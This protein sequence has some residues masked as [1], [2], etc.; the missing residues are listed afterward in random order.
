MMVDIGFLRG[1]LICG[2]LLR[3]DHNL[4]SDV[5]CLIIPSAETSEP[6][7]QKLNDLVWEI[8]GNWNVPLEFVVVNQKVAA[9]SM[10]TISPSF[11][12]HLRWAV[13]YGGVVGRNPLEM[14][15]VSG[16]DGRTDAVNYL[17]SKLRKLEK[18]S[19]SLS[20][21]QIRDGSSYI[22]ALERAFEAPLRVARV[23]LWWTDPETEKDSRQ[24]VLEEY[25]RVFAQHQDL[26]AD[27]GRITRE[28]EGYTQLL[29]GIVTG[30]FTALDKEAYESKLR[31]MEKWFSVSISFVLGNALILAQDLAKQ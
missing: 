10:H 24:E 1:A 18:D 3:G 19:Y 21:N 2:S 9:T 28:D 15:D 27:L 22:R 17:R 5:D 25:R 23:M 11:A 7:V 13:E 4:R 26:I 12:S 8:R 14:I 31:E 29:T 30:R 6:I 20:W 16:H